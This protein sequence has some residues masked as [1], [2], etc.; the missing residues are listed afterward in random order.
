MA[1]REKDS[2]RPSKKTASKPLKAVDGKDKKTP[3]IQVRLH[4][5]IDEILAKSMRRGSK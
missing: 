2:S 3:L 4:P 1:H 5:N